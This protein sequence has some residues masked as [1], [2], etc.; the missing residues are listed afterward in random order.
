VDRVLT[1]AGGE[2][3]GEGAEGAAAFS[4]LEPLNEKNRQSEDTEDDEEAVAEEDVAAVEDEEAR[5]IPGNEDDVDK[6]FVSRLRS[7]GLDERDCECPEG[8]EEDARAA[9]CDGKADKELFSEVRARGRT[10]GW[11]GERA[12]SDAE[13]D[14]QAGPDVDA[15]TGPATE[16]ENVL[17]FG[18]ETDDEDDTDEEE[19]VRSVKAVG[20]VKGEER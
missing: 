2:G 9:E 15:A 1:E 17:V 19:A 6:P 16:E 20:C 14:E 8:E 5:P 13:D 12:D 3:S 7:K 10:P 4:S 18:R 11:E